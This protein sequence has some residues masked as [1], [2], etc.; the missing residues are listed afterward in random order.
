MN[1]VCV[2]DNNYV[3]HCGVMLTSLFENNKG[4][5]IHIYLLTEGLS[6]ASKKSIENIIFNYNG[7]FHY[8]II[9]KSYFEKCPI[10]KGD[11]VNIAAYYRLVISSVLPLEITN[12]LYLDCDLIIRK[13]LKEIF[14][15][16]LKNK[17]LAAVNELSAC[18]H[19]SFVRLQYDSSYGYFNSGVLLV[20]LEYWR[21][22]NIENKL[23]NYINM[24]HDRIVFHDQDIL[25]AVLYN[26]WLPL[27]P[28]WN[29]IEPFYY[30][31]IEPTNIEINSLLKAPSILHYTWKRKPWHITCTHPL[32]KDYFKYLKLTEWKS[33]RCPF[34]FIPWSKL[35]V[36]RILCKMKFLPPMYKKI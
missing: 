10:R 9:D 35:L 11:H 1:I 22:N 7:Y 12:V 21:K 23:F 25:N 30:A 34:D 31:S 17:A 19:D 20:N 3:Q 26:Q 5:E 33:Y 6:E 29:M 28:K 24:Y 36:K 27:S 18:R 13:T 4:E 16:N 8:Y 14:D 15:I 32:K 2:T